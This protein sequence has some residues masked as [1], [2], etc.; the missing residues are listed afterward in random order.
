M[1]YTVTK[2][3]VQVIGKIWMPT[4]TAAQEYTLSDLDLKQYGIDKVNPNRE[5][6]F[7]WI[8]TNTGDFQSIDD[9]R[10]DIGEN[11]VLDWKDPESEYTFN[12]CMFPSEI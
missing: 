12:D 6:V 5:S 9:F 7:R 1:Q 4:I 8:L 2:N 3:I 10:A 11:K